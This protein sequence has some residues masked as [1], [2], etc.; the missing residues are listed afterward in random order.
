MN[1]DIRDVLYD[2]NQEMPDIYIV[3]LQEMVQLNTSQVVVGKD[4]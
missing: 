4:K 3:G 2:P 1:F